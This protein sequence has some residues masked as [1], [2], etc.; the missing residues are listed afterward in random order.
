MIDLN[1]AV[2]VAMADGPERGL[3]LM[4][5]IEG[6]DAYHLLHAARA[7]LLRRLGRAGD[8]ARA[9]EPV[10]GARAA[11]ARLA[12]GGAAEPTPNV[13]PRRSRPRFVFDPM[14]DEPAR[15]LTFARI[16]GHEARLSARQSHPSSMPA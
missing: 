12:R 4:D 2:A 16:A 1:R 7:D 10:S 13:E 3:A 15:L 8:D 11:A 9:A 6:L 5:T 14:R